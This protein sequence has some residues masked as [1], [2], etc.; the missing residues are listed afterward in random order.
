MIL[1]HHKKYLIRQSGKGLGNVMKNIIT[2]D[3]VTRKSKICWPNVAW[4]S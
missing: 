4:K 2:S 3:F 1:N